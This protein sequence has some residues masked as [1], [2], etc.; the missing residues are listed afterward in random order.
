MSTVQEILVQAFLFL[1]ILFGI[2]GN[3]GIL[4]FPDVYTRLQA[5]S[6]CSTT[7][8]F[9]IFIAGIIHSGPTP[10]TGK[11]LAISLFFLVSSPLSSHIIGNYAWK[12]GI[13][14]WKKREQKK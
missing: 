5:S 9:S 3:V 11:L 7:S 4:L 2:V 14:P 6:T 8:V 10:M 1:G 13:F 12:Q